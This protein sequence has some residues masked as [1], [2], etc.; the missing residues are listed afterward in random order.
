M[1]DSIPSP[2]AILLILVVLVGSNGLTYTLAKSSEEC[3]GQQKAQ[4]E[5][6]EQ[7]AQKDEEEFNRAFKSRQ[8][9]KDNR[10]G[11]LRITDDIR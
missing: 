1:F 11:G 9:L 8:D 3:S 4:I 2:K 5:T 6:L 10:S 7:R